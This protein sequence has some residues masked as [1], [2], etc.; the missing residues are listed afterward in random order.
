[1]ACHTRAPMKYTSTVYAAASGS[2]GGLTYS[3]NRG[4]LYTRRRAIPSNP[5]TEAQGL[6]RANIA[7]AVS[8]WTNT[9]TPTQ[10]TAWNTYANSTPTVDS[11]GQSQTLSGQQMFV[12][13]TTRRLLAGLPNILNGPVAAGL[14]LTPDWT[15]GPTVQEAGQIEGIVTVTGAGVLGDLLVYMSRPVLPSKTTAHETRRYADVEGPPIASLFTVAMDPPFLVTEGQ[16]VRVTCVY[17][18]DTGRMSAESWRDVIVAA[19]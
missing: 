17:A 7:T 8:L 4:G 14:G 10:R 3:R 6:A 5:A 12:A 13:N 1:M 11:L 2:V 16:A 9:L 19:A 18:D 15:T